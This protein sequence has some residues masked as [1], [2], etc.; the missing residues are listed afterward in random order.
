MGVFTTVVG[1]AVKPVKGA[2]S[3]GMNGVK[4]AIATNQLDDTVDPERGMLAKV[5]GVGYDALNI[6][7]LGV[8]RGVPNLITKKYDGAAIKDYKNKQKEDGKTITTEGMYNAALKADRGKV[9]VSRRID[10]LTEAAG[11]SACKSDEEPSL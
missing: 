5:G 3:A 1:T 4:K 6:A 10:S 11:L 8:A 9:A 7:T 2:F